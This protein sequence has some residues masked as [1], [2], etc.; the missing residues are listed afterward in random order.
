MCIRD[1]PHDERTRRRHEPE[2]RDGARGRTRAVGDRPGVGLCLTGPV[3]DGDLDAAGADRRLVRARVAV[4]LALARAG[5]V[6]DLTDLV[7]RQD[8]TEDLDLVDP[9][10]EER[11]GTAD[12]MPSS[13]EEIGGGV[14][15]PTLLPE[16]ARRDLVAVHV[17][18]DPARRTRDR[19]RD[20]VPE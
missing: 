8:P 4:L 19:P 14:G 2:P 6:V 10:P 15:D 7:A 17:E 9:S 16:R 3:A 5:C 20:V 18:T 13:D 1:R 11:R 12:R